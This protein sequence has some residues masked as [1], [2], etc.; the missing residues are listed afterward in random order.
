MAFNLGKVV[1]HFKH[2]EFAP[3]ETYKTVFVYLVEELEAHFNNL[4][5]SGFLEVG[6]CLKMF[7]DESYDDAI[8]YPRRRSGRQ[9][10]EHR[11]R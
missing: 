7:I 1:V 10:Y 6:M 4:D 5:Q 8:M 9:P 2:L 3:A 11:N